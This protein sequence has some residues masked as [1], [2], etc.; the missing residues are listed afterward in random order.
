VFVRSFF[1]KGGYVMK[2]LLVGLAPAIVVLVHA[3]APP[4][5][6]ACWGR[7][8]GCYSRY[9]CGYGYGYSSC[10]RPSYGCGYYGYSGYPNYG[11]GGYGY[12]GYGYGGYSPYGFAGFGGNSALTT[13]LAMNGMGGSNT[14]MYMTVPV[15]N[16][17]GPASLLQVPIGGAAGRS[18][19]L[20]VPVGGGPGQPVYMQ[21]EVGGGN[22]QA[23]PQAMPQTIAPMKPMSGPVQSPLDRLTAD[24][25]RSGD[26]TP[27]AVNVRKPATSFVAALNEAVRPSADVRPASK[28]PF[29][30]AV[31]EREAEPAA[32]SDVKATSVVLETPPTVVATPVDQ[33]SEIGLTIERNFSDGLAPWKVK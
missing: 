1:L 26:T 14:S 8:G 19:F 6:E 5:A 16:G 27:L 13:L 11:Y 29:H 9:S 20:Q 7:W 17:Y 32:T 31:Y 2:R 4:S 15:S 25:V 33:G 21:L 10:Y 23:M 24:D 30:F 18:T 3:M 28:S 22:A 12:S